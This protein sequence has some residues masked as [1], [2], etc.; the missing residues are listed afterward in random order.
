MTQGLGG[1]CL[2][3]VLH[4][5]VCGVQEEEDALLSTSSLSS[6]CLVPSMATSWVT[7]PTTCWHR[8]ALLS[9]QQ[10]ILKLRVKEASSQ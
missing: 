9:W 6:T 7:A 10:E 1:H 8:A 2:P 5:E 3:G 4:R